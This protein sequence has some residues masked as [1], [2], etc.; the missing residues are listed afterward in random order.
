MRRIR[1]GRQRVAG[2]VILT[3]EVRVAESARA[4]T[5]QRKGRMMGDRQRAIAQGYA[6]GQEDAGKVAT[7][8]REG[9]VTSGCRQFADA[10]S[11][12]CDQYERGEIGMRTNVRDAYKTW[13]L[14]GGLELDYSR[15]IGDGHA[16]RIASEWH[17]GQWSALYS[18]ASCGC[19]TEGTA[20][21]IR[22]ER[23]KF[24]AG[25]PAELDALLVYVLYAGERGPVNR[26]SDYWSDAPVR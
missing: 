11:E 2:P 7:G 23:Q 14:T 15:I 9:V 17:G 22:R 5:P 3:C 8:Q 6:W 24:A 10:Y 25:C 21:E 13:N 18:L 4:E 16:R 26:W 19:I 20:T 1:A 12:H